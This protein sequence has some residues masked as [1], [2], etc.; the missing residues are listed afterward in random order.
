MLIVP[1]IEISSFPCFICVPIS[2]KLLSKLLFKSKVYFSKRQNDNI[3]KIYLKMNY[4]DISEKW[5]G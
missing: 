5:L 4:N 2:F 3:N 1:K